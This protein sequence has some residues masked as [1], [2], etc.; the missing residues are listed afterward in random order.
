MNIKIFGKFLVENVDCFVIYII[1]V[2]D[3]SIR[4]DQLSISVTPANPVIGEG[5]TAQ[6]TATASDVNMTNFVYQWRKK[7]VSLPNKVFGVNRTVLTIPNLVES[8][9]G[10]YY[11]TVT[12]E[13]GNSV[14]S[15][16]VTLSVQGMVSNSYTMATRD[17]RGLQAKAHNHIK[18][19]PSGHGISNIYHFSMPTKKLQRRVGTT[20]SV[21]YKGI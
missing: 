19:I 8:D 6:F 10:I 4:T 17:L 11:C 5:G 15:G 20:P 12:N 16:D 7:H 13:W 14:S 18:G 1:F 21:L 2:Y 9:E 3:C